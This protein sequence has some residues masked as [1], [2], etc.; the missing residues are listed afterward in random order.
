MSLRFGARSPI[1]GQI[2]GSMSTF[3]A[4]RR[5]PNDSGASDSDRHALIEQLLLAGLDHYFSGRFE[6]AIHVWT[7]VFFL[8]RG[9][10]RARAY[11]ERARGVLAEH[12]R[13]AEAQGAEEALRAAQ[14]QAQAPPAYAS[15]SASVSAVRGAVE[16]SRTVDGSSSPRRFSRRDLL[17]RQNDAD[18]TP[19][20]DVAASV[21]LPA[22]APAPAAG[23]KLFAHVL[24]VSLAVVLLFG[25]GYVVVDRDRLAAWWRGPLDAPT[26]SLPLA[27]V[28][29]EPLP[30]PRPAEQ[31]LTRAKALFAGGHLQDAARLLSSIR[32]DDALREEADQLTADIQRAMLDAAGLPAPS[33]PRRSVTPI[34]ER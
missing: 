9:H 1:I 17:W 32:P 33:E 3:D 16:L 22:A 10:A 13:E 31:T 20:I 28:T 14:A 11:I 30:A 27:T 5:S 12:L 34:P 7:R 19:P 29:T 21:L 23:G 2:G 18:L 24:L 25:A 15:A 26:S 4:V 6:Q 8:D